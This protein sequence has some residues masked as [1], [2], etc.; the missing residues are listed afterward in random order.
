MLPLFPML[1]DTD[2]SEKPNN[3]ILD[4][5]DQKYHDATDVMKWACPSSKGFCVWSHIEL[6]RPS[7]AMLRM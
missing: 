1:H 2:G 4:K 5:P 7:R 3:V 6:L